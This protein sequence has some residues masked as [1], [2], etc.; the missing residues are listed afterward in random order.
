MMHAEEHME[1][2][3][4][5]NKYIKELLKA[6]L[7][8]INFMIEVGQNFK[9]KEKELNALNKLKSQINNVLTNK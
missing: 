8:G 5:E 9:D 2:M 6:T 1:L 3:R 7:P 4:G